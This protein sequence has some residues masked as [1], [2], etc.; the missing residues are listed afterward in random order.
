[1]INQKLTE[2]IRK[3]DLQKK[4]FS[5]FVN[6]NSWVVIPYIVSGIQ[7]YTNRGYVDY[8]INPEDAETF[9]R[10]WTGN[11]SCSA[12]WENS[13]KLVNENNTNQVKYQLGNYK[14]GLLVQNSSSTQVGQDLS[15]SEYTSEQIQNVVTFTFDGTSNTFNAYDMLKFYKIPKFS[16]DTLY[17]IVNIHKVYKINTKT[18]DYYSVTFTSVN[19]TF[20]NTG[21]ARQQNINMSS[22]GM[23]YL[24]PLVLSESE[25]KNLTNWQT[26]VE[27]VDYYKLIN[28]EY[29]TAS[30]NKINYNPVKKIVVKQ[31]G[32]SILR[33]VSCVVRPIYQNDSIEK[34]N[35]PRF[36]FLATIE[37]PITPTLYRTS[38]YTNNHYFGEFNPS[39]E[40]WT[41]FMESLK[42]TTST[43][44][45]ECK[46]DGLIFSNAN[47]VQA[48]NPIKDSG[49]YEFSL[50][51]ENSNVNGTVSTIQWLPQIQSETLSTPNTYG[52][53]SNYTFGGVSKNI[54]DLFWDNFWTGKNDIQIPMNMKQTTMVGS[55]INTG[56]AIGGTSLFVRK[57]WLRIFQLVTG[58]LLLGLGI[59]YT[60]AQKSKPSK[61]KPYRGIVSAPFY[62]LAITQFKPIQ[63]NG[64]IIPINFFKNDSSDNIT[65]LL[66]N[67]SNSFNTMIQGELSDAFTTTKSGFGSQALSTSSI[68]QTTNFE[69]ANGTKITVGNNT[70]N[71]VTLNVSGIESITPNRSIQGYIV[72]QVLIDSMFMG[73][74]SIEF[75]NASNEVVWSGIY[76][77]DA[78]WTG[79]IRDNWT[80]INTS[81]FNNDNI[82]SD[83]PNAYPSVVK[84][85]LIDNGYIPE[86]VDWLNGYYS[87]IVLAKSNS[88]VPS[89]TNQ[90][91]LNIDLVYSNFNN[92]ETPIIVFGNTNWSWAMLLNWFK[93]IK[94]VWYSQYGEWE[95]IIDFSNF[96]QR[97]NYYQVNLNIATDSGNSFITSFPLGEISCDTYV[98]RTTSQGRTNIV[99]SN[100]IVNL[101]N[102]TKFI[103]VVCQMTLR[104]NQTARQF[105][106]VKT[107]VN[108][109]A[110]F[111]GKIGNLNW[112]STSNSWTIN[113]NEYYFTNEEFN[114][115]IRMGIKSIHLIKY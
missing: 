67:S 82:F 41:D 110:G 22:P 42:D 86:N 94:V 18:I 115:E 15:Y 13:I 52:V 62:D 28:G 2:D 38:Q 54:C 59:G 57:N 98:T 90:R 55:F 106:L 84:E 68:G 50:Y 12:I 87:S 30:K 63:A 95:Q 99:K 9:K 61:V 64:N 21:R 31:Y 8:D 97:N 32:T 91:K 81:V 77:S 1:M 16:K 10:V 14:L 103:N 93:Y 92:S 51:Q 7:N 36:A 53:E 35:S 11:D 109:N 46:Y 19:Q 113:N 33:S 40:S 58:A 83:I 20:S 29:L 114:K 37:E 100:T 49:E 73:D 89:N 101:T 23:G 43:F 25:F 26:L 44:V 74:I 17:R 78:K 85:P 80:V 4:E 70:T 34:F 96:T 102:Q 79:N 6:E 111:V 112:N 69:L 108:N 107:S 5:A 47:K 105:E 39:V 27:G 3:S 48:T 45:S 104:F 72:E 65:N 75:L 71:V 76:Q 66:F 60:V 88:P 56:L 24:N